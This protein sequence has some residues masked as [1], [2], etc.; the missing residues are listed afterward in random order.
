MLYEFLFNSDKDIT[1]PISTGMIA[2]MAMP[3]HYVPL[4]RRC[5]DTAVI[6]SCGREWRPR[7]EITRKPC[8][9]MWKDSANYS[10]VTLSHCGVVARALDS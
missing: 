3:T 7:S 1:I 8:K 2:E 10:V 4:W 9:N 5:H 6:Q